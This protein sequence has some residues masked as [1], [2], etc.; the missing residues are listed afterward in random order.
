MFFIESDFP[1]QTG[2]NIINRSS[3]INVKNVKNTCIRYV[4]IVY[5]FFLHCYCISNYKKTET[6]VCSSSIQ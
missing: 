5:V 3:W 4:F 2:T 1:Q 6:D